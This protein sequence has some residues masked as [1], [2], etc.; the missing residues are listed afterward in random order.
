MPQPLH[1]SPLT[2]SNPIFHS[3]ISTPDKKIVIFNMYNTDLVMFY[4][5]NKINILLII[6]EF[7]IILYL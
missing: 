4:I 7:R 1:P 3:Q 2:K 5:L 6:N